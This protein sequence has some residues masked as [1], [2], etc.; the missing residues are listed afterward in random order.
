MLKNVSKISIGSMMVLALACGQKESAQDAA[1]ARQDAPKTTKT[2]AAKETQ[3]EAE[4]AALPQSVIIA[5]PLDKNGNE[6]VD[7][8]EM[9]T[10]ADSSMVIDQ[11]VEATFNAGKSP[12][13]VGKGEL[14]ADSS[15]QS[16]R[17]W[18]P[19][20]R[21][22]QGNSYRAD[23][24]QDNDSD[25][26]I[27]DINNSNVDVNV[28]QTNNYYQNQSYQGGY[29]YYSNYRP[30]A[31]SNSWRG[32]YWGYSRPWCFQRPLV[33]YYVYQRSCCSYSFCGRNSNWW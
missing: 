4:Y 1:P 10:Q 30:R 26:N 8:A 15:T 24:D 31:Y 6:L 23:V 32:G 7:Q 19:N 3:L 17:S 25:I 21:G 16:W 14:D 11:N 28:N 18:R 29:G 22:D 2:D 12:A 33:R 27:S 5:V 20:R 9:K 13:K